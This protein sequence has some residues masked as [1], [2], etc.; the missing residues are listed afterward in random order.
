MKDKGKKKVNVAID[1][2]EPDYAWLADAEKD[3]AAVRSL[4]HLAIDTYVRKMYCLP[5]VMP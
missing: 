3:Q 2:E 5:A 4:M 1:T